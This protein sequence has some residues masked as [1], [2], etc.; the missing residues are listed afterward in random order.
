MSRRVTDDLVV[1]AAEALGH[2]PLER[3]LVELGVLERIEKVLE[4]L[5][6]DAAAERGDERAVEPAREVAADGHVGAQH[7][8]ARRHPRGPPHR[9]RRPRR[10]VPAKALARVDRDSVGS[11]NA[12]SV[13]PARVMVRTCPGSS[14]VMPANTACGATSSRT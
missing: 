8:Q 12:R 13:M 11:Q 10:C 1:V 5:A 7:A 3:G 6:L 4:P 14:S 2:Q 9:L